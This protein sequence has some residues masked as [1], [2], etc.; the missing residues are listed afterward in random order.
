MQGGDE[1]KPEPDAAAGRGQLRVVF[2]ESTRT[3]GRVQQGGQEEGSSAGH[4]RGLWLQVKT[5]SFGA[6]SSSQ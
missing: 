6:Q 5:V 1:G 3:S 4:G 2:V